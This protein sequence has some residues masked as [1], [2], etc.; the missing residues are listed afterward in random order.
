MSDV[1]NKI[2]ELDNEDQFANFDLFKSTVFQVF[3]KHVPLKKKYVRANQAPFIDKKINKEIM[4]RS[5]LR[6]RFFKTKNETDREN[7]NRQRNFC[8]SMI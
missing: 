7:Y 1:K 4:K 6:N 3:E 8:L 2:S 5:R